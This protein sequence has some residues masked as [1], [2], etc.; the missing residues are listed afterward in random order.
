MPLNK[1]ILTKGIEDFQKDGDPK[2]LADAI[3]N[4]IKS[5]QL[6][7]NTPAFAVTGTAGPVPVVGTTIPV[8]IVSNLSGSLI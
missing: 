1:Q 7:I 6:I 3:E 4:Y 5:G 2:K 8:P